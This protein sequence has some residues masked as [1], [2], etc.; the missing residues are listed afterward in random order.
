MLAFLSFWRRD[1]ESPTLPV[2]SKERSRRVDKA[3]IGQPV[4][5]FIPP[6][7]EIYATECPREPLTRSSSHHSGSLPSPSVSPSSPTSLVARFTPP[8]RDNCYPLIRS[9]SLPTPVCPPLS[10][11]NE[12]I[13]HE[14]SA[15]PAAARAN[16]FSPLHVTIHTP[17]SPILENCASPVSLKPTSPKDSEIS[18]L[19]LPRPVVLPPTFLRRSLSKS[20]TIED[21]PS[22]PA[23]NLAPY[24]PGPHPS[25]D[26]NGPLRRPPRA[27]A[28]PVRSSVYSEGATRSSSGSLHAESFVTA[29]NSLHIPGD[30]DLTP[31][32]GEHPDAIVRSE[33]N[34]T[35]PISHSPV[36]LDRNNTPC[37]A[38]MRLRRQHFTFATPAFCAFWLGFLFPPIW[39]VGGWYFTFFAETPPSRTLW[40]HYVV[41]TRWWGVLTC[42]LT[43]R[44]GR[45]KHAMRADPKKPLLL[46]LW[47]GRNNTRASLKG[48]SYYYPYVSRPAPGEI[49]HV[50][51]GPPPLGFRYLHEFFDW[52]TGS[53]LARVK[54]DWESPR[55]IIDPWIQ[56]CRRALCYW[57]LALLLLVLAIMSWSIAVGSGK[58][59]Y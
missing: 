22:L 20:Q 35:V 13:N 47:V 4:L 43:R 54:L 1:D 19:D 39:W 53:R 9:Y 57:C 6:R 11:P 50:T 45:S 26:G 32:P 27:L 52:A 58:A 56:R 41:D 37:S 42:G 40:E 16:S 8:G 5:R 38:S 18:T 2:A 21:P 48:I 34:S 30:P 51:T 3:S 31:I 59:H 29:S 24:F 15:S 23:L 12:S 36:H 33:T 44:K 49:G 10:T 55:R 25:Q 46:P 28:V 17:L 14:S 7:F